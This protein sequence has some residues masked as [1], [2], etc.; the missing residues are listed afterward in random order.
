[1][2][3]GSLALPAGGYGMKL[4]PMRV[5]A[6]KARARSKELSSTIDGVTMRQRTSK[7]SFV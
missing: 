7:V 2:Q 3:V 4:W 5:R 6:R 1:M